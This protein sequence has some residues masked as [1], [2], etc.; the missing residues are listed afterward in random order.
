MS[1]NNKNIDKKVEDL[2]A[3]KEK[4]LSE[5]TVISIGGYAFTP[6]KLMIA[7]TIVTSVLGGLYGSFEIYKDYMDMK[8]KIA[9]YVTPDL[10][11]IY[12]KIEVLDASTNKTVEYSQ[13]IKNDLKA[14][15]RRLENVVE[16]VERDSKVAQRDTDKSVQDA[17]KDVRE[18]KQ[19]VDKI[20]RQ[21][22]KDTATQ[23]KELQR[24]VETAV[25]QL[26]KENEAEIKQLRRELDDKIKKALDNPLANK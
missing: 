19:E 21:L 23:N 24:Q 13:D 18:T 3:A 4:Y 1:D 9:D 16:S 22:E 26:Q 15:I 17:R 6:A 14:D 11:E 20:T 8:Q 25:R 7:G 2:E 10:G 5:N 12:K